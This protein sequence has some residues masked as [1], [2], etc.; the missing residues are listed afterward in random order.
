MRPSLI[1]L[2]A[3]GALAACSHT[4]TSSDTTAQTD[5]ANRVLATLQHAGQHLGSGHQYGPPTG[6]IRVANVLELSGQPSGPVDLYD[7]RTPDSTATPL[8]KNLAFGQI[9]DYVSPRAAD[10]YPNSPS[11]LYIFPAGTKQASSPYGDRIDNSG[12][13]SSDQ[14]TV[15]LGTTHFSGTSAI[16]LPALDEAGQRLNA[17]RDSMRVIPSGQALLVLLQGN[18]SADSL[19]ELYLMIDGTCPLT[20]SNPRNRNPTAIGTDINFA[21]TPGAHTLGIVTSP[22]GHG[23]L[24]CTG[25]KPG[26]TASVTVTAGQR[27]AV[28]IYGLPSDGFRVLTAPIAVP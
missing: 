9:S 13:A 26:Q 24:N 28:L 1:A 7:T 25:K 6:K 4:D 22:R 12:Y 27:Y 20:S 14:T 16:A 17:N 18:M 10:N 2:A 11:N 8:I 15:A 3:V 21:V 5:S 19:P 23:L